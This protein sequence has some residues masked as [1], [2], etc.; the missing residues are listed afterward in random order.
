MDS[1]DAVAKGCATVLRGA[2]RNCSQTVEGSVRENKVR[3][4]REG[5]RQDTPVDHQVDS[6]RAAPGLER[7]GDSGDDAPPGSVL[8]A[9]YQ[10]KSWASYSD[11][12]GVL[13]SA[14][15]VGTT[16]GNEVG[17]V[18]YQ[19][20]APWAK[21]RPNLRQRL[22]E[23]LRSNESRHAGILEYETQILGRKQV[24]DG[25]RRLPRLL[26]GEHG[27]QVALRVKQQD[28]NGVSRH[29]IADSG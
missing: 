19:D 24:V 16:G 27:D 10:M 13:V 20:L 1:P 22:V 28:P 6:R 4:V 29:L 26:D 15:A 21:Q 23:K 14:A 2:V 3:C 7:K 25:Y 17:V 5:L 9:H 12:D 18:G 11:L 8:R